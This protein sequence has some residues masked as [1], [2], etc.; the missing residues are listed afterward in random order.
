MD[1][2]SLS[3]QYLKFDNELE[4]FNIISPNF[5]FRNDIR[6]NEFEVTIDN[7]MRI[8]LIFQSMYDLEPNQVY[9]LE[10]V[11]IILFIN[12]ISNPLNIKS[13]M[14]LSYP[15]LE[16]IGKFRL[17]PSK[18]EEEKVSIKERLV[19]P[20]KSTK[21]DKD[22]EKFKENNYLLPPVVLDTPRPPV[23]INGGKFSIGGL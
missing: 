1:I 13:G 2:Q 21:K 16:D 18:L 10:D 19:V 9:L 6:L 8:D 23:R 5:F 12:N 11:D 20:N 17:E 3:S 7:E 4:I 15:S 22:R 14:V